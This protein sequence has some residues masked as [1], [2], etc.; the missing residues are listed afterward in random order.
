MFVFSKWFS[1]AYTISL[2]R[3][4][5]QMIQTRNNGTKKTCHNHLKTLIG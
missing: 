2:F 4:T 5:D 1:A 3:E